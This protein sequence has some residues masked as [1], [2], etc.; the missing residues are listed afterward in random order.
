MVLRVQEFKRL[1]MKKATDI[2]LP[3]G[4][5]TDI[6]TIIEQGRRQAYAQLNATMIDTYWMI[7]RRIVE[8]EQNGQNRA[9]YGKGLIDSLSRQLSIEYGEGFS[10]RYLRAFRQFYSAVPDYEIWKSGFPNLTWTHIYRTLRVKDNKAIRWYLETA[11]QEMWSTKMLNRNISTQYY[12]RHLLAP[13]LPMEKTDDKDA[14]E[15]V[16]NPVMAEFL[17]IKQHTKYVETDLETAIIDHMQEFMMELGRGFAFVKRQQ[18]V[19]TAA[20]DYYIDLVFY[21]YILKCFVLIDLKAGKVTHQ[22]VGQMDMYVRM[23]DELKRTD[24]DNPTIGILL[25]SETD[26]D[27]ARYSVLNDNDHLF[28]TKYMLYMPTKEQLRLEIE[29]E[30]EIYRLQHEEKNILENTSGGKLLQ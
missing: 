15:F 14:G 8:E 19:R 6:R 22:D 21:N 26:E 4:F 13:S 3:S 29:R 10:A 2:L 5:L 27:I 11:S 17:G 16:K 23:Y 12:E 25:C 30:K 24:G 9:E 28:Q 18:L 20:D 1:R 7:G